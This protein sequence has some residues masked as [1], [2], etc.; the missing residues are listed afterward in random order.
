MCA[1]DARVLRRNPEIDCI[2]FIHAV[3]CP[4]N[5][6]LHRIS[7]RALYQGRTMTADTFHLRQRE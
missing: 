2:L 1:D 5:H 7:C 3:G 6:L 4:H